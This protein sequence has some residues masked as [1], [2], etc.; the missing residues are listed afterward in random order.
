MANELDASDRIAGFGLG[1]VKAALKRVA[2]SGDHVLTSVG[3]ALGC[4][5]VQATR[6]LDELGRRGFVKKGERPG[7]WVNTE[8][9][10][11]LAYYWAPPRRFRPAIERDDADSPMNQ[12]L[13]DVP[14]LLLRGTDDDEDHFEEARIEAGF[15]TEYDGDHLVEVNI[16]QPEDYDAPSGGIIELSAYISPS[17]AR[18]LAVGLLKAADLADAE[19]SRRA[20]TPPRRSFAP[21]AEA[22]TRLAFSGHRTAADIPPA[23]G[24]GDA[25]AR[26][27]AKTGSRKA[28]AEALAELKRTNRARAQGERGTHRE[29]RKNL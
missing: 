24:D 5:P 19:I 2:F 1:S 4:G 25:Q 27:P 13:E 20:S 3:E 12:G 15:L 18:A 22:E 17:R 11:R 29:T 10:H 23:A 21:S 14:C 28:V 16:V 9:G 6:V 26:T 8:K 7:Q